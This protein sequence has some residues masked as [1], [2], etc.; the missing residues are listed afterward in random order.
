MQFCEL[1]LGQEFDW[2]D[3]SKPGMNSFFDPCVKTSERRYR[4]T[5]TNCSYTVGTV[6]AKVF[7]VKPN[8]NRA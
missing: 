1:A 5:L 4:S 6:K 7:H 2:V 8:R 3:D